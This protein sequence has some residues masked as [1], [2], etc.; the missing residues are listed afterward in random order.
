MEFV[1]Q[2]NHFFATFD[3]VRFVAWCAAGWFIGCFLGDLF[4]ELLGGW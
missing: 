4:R 3:I 2:V 1:D